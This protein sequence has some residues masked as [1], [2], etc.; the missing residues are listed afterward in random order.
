MKDRNVASM[1][2]NQF[3]PRLFLG[4]KGEGVFAVDGL[5]AGGVLVGRLVAGG[6]L[7]GGLV[8][9]GFVVGGLVAGGFLAGGF[10]VGGFAVT[11]SIAP[12]VVESPTAGAAIGWTGGGGTRSRGR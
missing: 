10:L 12:V 11:A 1:N 6:L 7:V 5:V 8:T 2:E 4:F 3:L 9:G